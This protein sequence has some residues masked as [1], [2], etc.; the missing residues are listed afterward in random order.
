MHP[1]S[2]WMFRISAESVGGIFRAGAGD[3]EVDEVVGG[4]SVA[5]GT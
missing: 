2:S 4:A 5:K 1:R 3:I